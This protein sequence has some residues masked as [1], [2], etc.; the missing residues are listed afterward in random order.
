M[1]VRAS[2]IF[3]AKRR[4][5]FGEQRKISCGNTG[6]T[7]EIN[8]MDLTGDH[9]KNNEKMIRGDSKENGKRQIGDSMH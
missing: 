3:E 6:L 7:V 8:N 5:C 4:K 2:A 1:A 9:D